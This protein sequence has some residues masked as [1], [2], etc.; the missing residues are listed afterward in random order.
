MADGPVFVKIQNPSKSSN[1]LQ[2][3]QNR[4]YLCRANVEGQGFLQNYRP[5]FVSDLLSIILF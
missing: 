1:K 2:T 3:E 5:G 4:R